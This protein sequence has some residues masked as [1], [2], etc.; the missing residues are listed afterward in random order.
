MLQA[1]NSKNKNSQIYQ[2]TKSGIEKP[3]ESK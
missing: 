1:V 2:Y 3:K